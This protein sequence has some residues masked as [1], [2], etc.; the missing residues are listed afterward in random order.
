MD[1]K[2]RETLKFGVCAA[3]LAVTGAGS[4]MPQQAMAATKLTGVYYIPP[5]YGDLSYG[6]D[7]FVSLVKK[8]SG[9]KVEIDYYPASQLVKADEQLPAL[10][11]RSVDLMFHTVSYITRSVPVLGITGLPGIVGE[12]YA[13]PER[14]AKGSPLFELINAQLA[15]E[16]LYM[17]SAGGGLFEPEFI[18]STKANPIRSLADLQGKKV[19]VVGFEATQALA[20]FKSSAVRVPSSETY[21]ALQRGTVDAGVFNISTVVGRSLQEQLAYCLKIPTTGYAICPFMLRDRWDKLNP[22]AKAALESASAWYEANFAKN[23]NQ[24]VYPKQ[25]WPK[26]QQ[27]GVQVIEPSADDMK[28]F[29]AAAVAVWDEWKKQVG[30]ELGSRAIAL[31]LGKA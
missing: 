11:S 18:W 13:H 10:R 30:E 9:G 31:A 28:K 21:L 22:D 29:D 2:R 15:K 1:T 8:N 12:L 26:V 25:H 4:F 23:A 19:R 16:N 17:L 3:A 27:A 5:S 7:G 20:T 6:P 24:N 14:L